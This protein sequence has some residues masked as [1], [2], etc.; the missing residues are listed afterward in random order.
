MARLTYVFWRDIP[1]QVIVAKG[2]RDQ[3]KK[4]LDERF[5]KAIDRAAMRDDAKDSESYLADW[6]KEVVGEVSDDMAME[7][8]KAASALEAKFDNEA[9]KALVNNGGRTVG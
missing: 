2:R 5:E 6:R 7:A 9:L 3:V 4:P 8:D 1:A